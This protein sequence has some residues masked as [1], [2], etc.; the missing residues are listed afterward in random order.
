MEERN[1]TLYPMLNTFLKAPPLNRDECKT[2]TSCTMPLTFTL[3][4]PG[5]GCGNNALWEVLLHQ[6]HIACHSPIAGP[7]M[8]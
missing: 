5:C 2:L 8:R 3:F 4:V 6:L 7:W 1:P